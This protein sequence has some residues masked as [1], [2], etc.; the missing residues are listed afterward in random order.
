MTFGSWFLVQSILLANSLSAS[1]SG[2]IP[3]KD[4]TTEKPLSG[5]ASRAES[6]PDGGV[7][8]S[9]TSV[10]TPGEVTHVKLWLGR[11]P[12][13]SKQGV[14]IGNE[15]NFVLKDLKIAEIDATDIQY[16]QK[17]RYR[18]I[19]LRDLIAV[20]RPVPNS[21]DMVVLH[22][23]NG[24][25]IPITIQDLMSDRD[26]FLATEV[27]LNGQWTKQFPEVKL[28]GDRTL[29]FLGNKLVAGQFFSKGRPFNPWEYSASLSGVELVESRAY[30]RSFN[31]LDGKSTSL[32]HTIFQ[33]RCWTCHSV[34]N[35]GGS[36]GPDLT[37]IKELDSRTGIKQLHL[38]IAGPTKKGDPQLAHSMP[39]QKDFTMKEAK[40]LW[41]WL[42]EVKSAP[43]APYSPSYQTT[44]KWE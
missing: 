5:A 30:Y 27:K 8:H 14:G 32:G 37:K 23:S 15:R 43:L 11:H 4:G 41:F 25:R 36:W 18:G 20:M 29:A 9:P 38:R 2:E 12:G 33:G 28:A 31:R 19:N 16:K 21:V 17:N 6:T 40:S 24:L 26:V 7:T 22:T 3:Q 13:P 39:N 10:A 42:Q 44:V 34:Q 1:T 35:L